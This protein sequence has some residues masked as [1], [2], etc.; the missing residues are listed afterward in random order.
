MKFWA[1]V[2]IIALAVGAY[3]YSH[4]PLHYPPGILISDDPGQVPLPESASP[5]NHG[6]FVLKPLALFSIDARVLHKRNYSYDS[7]AAL[8]P[9]DLALGW[10]PMSNQAVLD[11]LRISQSMTTKSLLTKIPSDT[12]FVKQCYYGP[13]EKKSCFTMNCHKRNCLHAA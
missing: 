3:W 5:I 4:R 6:A 12:D 8:V 10:G 7:G 11:R 1:A 9:V 2:G 13:S